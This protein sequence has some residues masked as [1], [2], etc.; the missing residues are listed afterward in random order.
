[1]IALYWVLNKQVL[2]K[3]DLTFFTIPFRL[4]FRLL[5]RK[6]GCDLAFTPMIISDSFIQAPKARDI[7]F[8]T[9]DGT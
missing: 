8:T 7:E 2:S 1:M 4:P 3:N 5:V 6:Y 9:C